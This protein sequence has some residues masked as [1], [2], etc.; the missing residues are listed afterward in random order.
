MAEQHHGADKNEGM[1]ILCVRPGARAKGQQEGKEVPT[2]MQGSLH[3]LLEA[4]LGV[5]CPV[6][7]CV[8]VTPVGCQRGKGRGAAVTRSVALTARAKSPLYALSG[9]EAQL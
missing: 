4:V 3:L 9:G 7:Q 5:R 2:T 8:P 6:E 1:D